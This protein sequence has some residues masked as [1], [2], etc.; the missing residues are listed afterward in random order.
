[1][2]GVP[3]EGIAELDPD[4]VAF[5]VQR[6]RA[7][8]QLRRQRV[9][10]HNK[11]AVN[12]TPEYEAMPSRVNVAVDLGVA[13]AVVQEKLEVGGFAV[14]HV[15]ALEQNESSRFLHMLAG[16]SAGWQP[17]AIQVRVVP[18]PQQR[19]LPDWHIAKQC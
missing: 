1:M 6:L 13:A 16:Q 19:V 11:D 15:S 2:N 18:M 3:V 8:G 7:L 14:A 5:V 10:L 17:L 12:R 4:Q 9:Q